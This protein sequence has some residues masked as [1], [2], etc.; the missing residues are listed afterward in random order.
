MRLLVVA[1]FA[2]LLTACSGYK[3][4]PKFSADIFTNPVLVKVKIDSED[5]DTGTYLEDE[6]ARMAIN[7]LNLTLTKRVKEANGY[8]LVNSYTINTTPINKDKNGNVIRYSVNSAIEFAIKDKY[9][10]WSKNIVAGAYVTVKPQ[11]LMSAL[12]KEKATKLAIKLALDEFVADVMKRS[13]EM[14]K[15]R[16]DMPKEKQNKSANAQVNN[17]ANTTAENSEITDTTNTASQSI[18]STEDSSIDT[19]SDTPVDTTD[20]SVDTT[21]SDNSDNRADSSVDNTTGFGDSNPFVSEIPDNSS[22][23]SSD[24]YATTSDSTATEQSTEDNF[25]IKIIP[26]DNDTPI[27]DAT[28]YN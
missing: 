16:L 3:P 25:G 27:Q 5:P 24:N 2:F 18:D 13:R 7:R 10:F 11:S 28:T 4:A 26:T 23:T 21:S 12:D 9:G 15:N 8:I 14:D 1:F 6:I 19:S 20:S 17:S 22:D